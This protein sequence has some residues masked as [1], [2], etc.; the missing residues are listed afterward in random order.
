M[1]V[2]QNILFWEYKKHIEVLK[3]LPRRPNPLLE[4]ARRVF[5]LCGRFLSPE[6]SFPE[7]WERNPGHSEGLIELPEGVPEH[8][9]AL[10]ELPEEF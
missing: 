4:L 1:Q 10:I 2:F 7:H 3:S 9:E 6:N 5:E 8:W